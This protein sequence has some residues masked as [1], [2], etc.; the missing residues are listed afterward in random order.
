MHQAHWCLL[1][2]CCAV[3][4]VLLSGTNAAAPPNKV[5]FTDFSGLSGTWSGMC[6]Q[7]AYVNPDIPNAA[8]CGISLNEMFSYPF[9]VTFSGTA[10]YFANMG[11]FTKIGQ[12]ESFSASRVTMSSYSVNRSGT[13]IFEDALNGGS[14]CVTVPGA[15]SNA[16]FLVTLTK[17]FGGFGTYLEE[18]MRSF[19]KNETT[20]SLLD[21]PSDTNLPHQCIL[22]PNGRTPTIY[23]YTCYAVVKSSIFA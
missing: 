8:A 6:T 14:K 1:V 12:N 15:S 20:A 10:G 16:K 9:A 23:S 17:G 13:A 21:C 7:T 22:D 2:L 11:S 3:L 5:I 4:G 18:G 19:S